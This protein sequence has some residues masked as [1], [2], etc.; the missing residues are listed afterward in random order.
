LLT[1]NEFEAKLQD[2]PLIA[3]YQFMLEDEN[4]NE[5]LQ[6]YTSRLASVEQQLTKLLGAPYLNNSCFY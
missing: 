6:D 3:R 1:K 2:D 5:K 4:E